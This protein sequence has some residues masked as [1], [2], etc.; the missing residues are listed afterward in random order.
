MARFGRE[1]ALSRDFPSVRKQPSKYAS[2]DRCD[3]LRRRVIYNGART[4]LATWRQKPLIQILFS[5]GRPGWR[6]VAR[7]NDDS[8]RALLMTERSSIPPVSFFGRNR[9]PTRPL[10]SCGDLLAPHRRICK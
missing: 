8:I 2:V 5:D 3:L 6:L 4:G 9:M 10:L 1:T 7:A